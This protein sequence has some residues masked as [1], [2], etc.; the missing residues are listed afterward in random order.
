[1]RSVPGLASLDIGKKTRASLVKGAGAAGLRCVRLTTTTVDLATTASPFRH[2]IAEK[3]NN[4]NYRHRFLREDPQS[5]SKLFK[6]KTNLS[7][8]AFRLSFH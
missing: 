2:T 6:T 1:M 7:P 5:F 4:E 3:E 8:S